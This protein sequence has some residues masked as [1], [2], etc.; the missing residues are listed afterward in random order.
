MRL[1]AFSD[2]HRDRR[3]ARRLVELAREADVVVGAGDFGSMHL[4]ISRTIEPLKA[5]TAPVVI[6]PGNSE[7][8]AELWRACTG[9][10]SAS[11]LHGESREI[12]GVQF[13]GLGGGIPETPFPW[14]FDLSEE[15]AEEKLRSCP[16]EAVMVL[17][18][19]P[20]GHVDDAHGRSLGSEA[21]LRAIERTCPLLAV[22][23]HIH[24]S[25]GSESRI[26]STR[27][28]NLGPEGTFLEV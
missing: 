11:M 1:L 13:F 16:Q 12:G 7:T 17:H 18:S 15:Q 6:V 24:Q 14:S 21:I 10:Q 2:L 3:Q 28:V 22:C 27:V 9:W 20:K 26:A 5:I 8:D 4:G 25:W 23:G 19:P